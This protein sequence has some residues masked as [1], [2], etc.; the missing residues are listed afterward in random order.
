[1]SKDDSDREFEV[2][3][4]GKSS[5]ITLPIIAKDAKTAE[6][7]ASRLIKRRR[8]GPIIETKEKKK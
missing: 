7:F 8:L 3:V 5:R 1:M 2:I 6:A 4:Q